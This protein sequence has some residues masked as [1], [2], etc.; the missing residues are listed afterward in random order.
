MSLDACLFV[1]TP[2]NEGGCCGLRGVRISPIPWGATNAGAT[3][4][5]ERGLMMGAC[6]RFIWP[7]GGMSGA[8][9]GG[10]WAGFVMTS[11]NVML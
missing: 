9:S 11:D 1:P 2:G 7:G 6:S 3:N 4:G 10:C 8:L 5:A